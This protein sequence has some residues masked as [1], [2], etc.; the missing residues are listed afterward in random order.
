MPISKNKKKEII[1]ELKEKLAKQK[2]LVFVDFT[3]VKVKDL[4]LFRKRLKE[5]DNELRVAKK[6]LAQIVF[7][8]K[9]I[10]VDVKKLKGE[11]GFIFGYNDEVSSAKKAWQFSKENQNLKILGGVIGDEVFD[12]EKMTAIAQ[13]PSKEELLAKLV[14][15]INAPVSNFVYALNYNIKG[16]VQVLSKI[17]T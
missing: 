10:K 7:K 15:S 11:I 5:G 4:S 9:G 14:G 13:L 8:E 1:E 16:L 2:S 3:G 17:K 6:T 12:F